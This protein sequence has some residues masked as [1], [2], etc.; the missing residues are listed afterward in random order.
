MKVH[1]EIVATTDE[2]PNA[3]VVGFLEEEFSISNF[4]AAVLPTEGNLV[5]YATKALWLG[6]KMVPGEVGCAMAHRQIMQRFLASD[7]DWALVLENDV[8]VATPRS[9][10]DLLK[11]NSTTSPTVLMLGFNLDDV[12]SL[13]MRRGWFSIPSI[14]TGTFAYAIN[15]PAAKRS[16]V[17][18]PF[19]YGLADWPLFLAA[20]TK[21]RLF[22]PPLF[23]HPETDVPTLITGRELVSRRFDSFRAIGSS[24]SERVPPELLATLLRLTLVR[25]LLRLARRFESLLFG[26]LGIQRAK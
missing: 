22:Y 4:H 10:M 12:P 6:R 24:P 11:S 20:T 18:T 25:D 7:N 19:N 13:F 26:R 1:V 14:P 9:I 3:G 17:E 15:R 16:L 23:A 21:F 5:E 2:L 8:A